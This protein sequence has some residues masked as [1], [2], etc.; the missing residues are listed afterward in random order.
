MSLIQALANLNGLGGKLPGEYSFDAYWHQV[1]NH[2]QTP[3]RDKLLGLLLD[4]DRL[5]REHAEM[6]HRLAGLDK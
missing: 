4:H 3:D 6:A 2:N 5:K 1:F